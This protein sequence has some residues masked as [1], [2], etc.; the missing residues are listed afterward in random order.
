MIFV[1]INRITKVNVKIN[2]KMNDKYFFNLLLLTVYFHLHT[3]MDLQF[4]RY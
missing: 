1:K 4:N 2:L 3:R